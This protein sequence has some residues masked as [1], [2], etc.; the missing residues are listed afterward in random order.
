MLG[1]Y[2]G[3]RTLILGLETQ[4]L[5]LI[6][7]LGPFLV[8]DPPW[9]G[10][11]PL[12]RPENLGLTRQ[13]T[14]NIVSLTHPPPPG[15]CQALHRP[16]KWGAIELSSENHFLVVTAIP[17]PDIQV[18]TVTSCPDTPAHPDLPDRHQTLPDPGKCLAAL[19]PD[20]THTATPDHP[21]PPHSPENTGAALTGGG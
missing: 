1:Q 6:W 11:E 10:R 21:P 14:V 9:P 12:Q 18:V 19:V 15:Q 7:T 8:T 20:L 5:S 16:G 4:G 3:P 2:Q 13:S 17:C